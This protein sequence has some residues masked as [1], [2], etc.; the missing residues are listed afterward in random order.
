[1][2][3]DKYLIETERMELLA[4]YV[5]LLYEVDVQCLLNRKGQR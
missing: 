2:L 4:L 3:E 1:M 5:K